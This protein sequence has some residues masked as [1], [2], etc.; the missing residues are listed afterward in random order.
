MRSRLWDP[1]V[2]IE[3]TELPTMGTMLRDQIGS[4]R[5]EPQAEMVTRYREQ[6]Y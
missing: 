3:R 2:Q 1:D 6:L 5:V 4:G